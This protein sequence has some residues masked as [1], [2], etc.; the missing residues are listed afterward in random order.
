MDQLTQSCIHPSRSQDNE[1]SLSL[2]KSGGADWVRHPQFVRSAGAPASESNLKVEV[3]V[4]VIEDDDDADD[5]EGDRDFV[6]VKLT[7]EKETTVGAFLDKVI[8]SAR[9]TTSFKLED[10]SRCVFKILGTNHNKC[11]LAYQYRI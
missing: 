11:T 6:Q 3:S 2:M 8:K 5:D 4:P 10:L 7:V 1:L 9:S